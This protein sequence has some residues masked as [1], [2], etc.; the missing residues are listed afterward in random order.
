MPERLRLLVRQ[1]VTGSRFDTD[2][3]QGRWARLEFD[4]SD[5]RRLLEAGHALG[6]FSSREWITDVDV[7]TAVVLT[8]LDQLVPP[9]RQHKL[10]AAI[11]DA[12]VF[13]VR[14]DHVVCSMAPQVFAPTLVQAGRD[15]AAR[16][17]HRPT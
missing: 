16:S 14:G 3:P 1:R 10:A 17:T 12:R 6:R 11:P 8:E 5:G 7:P 2:T 13:P 9:H 4:R 15:V